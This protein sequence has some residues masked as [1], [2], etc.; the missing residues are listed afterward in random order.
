MRPQLAPQHAHRLCAIHQSA[1]L[2]RQLVGSV[3]CQELTE[4]GA[5][6]APILGPLTGR[7]NLALSQEYRNCLDPQIARTGPKMPSDLS[8]ALRPNVKP[9]C[10]SPAGATGTGPLRRGV[11]H[12]LASKLSRGS[13]GTGRS[14]S[15]RPGSQ[16]RGINAAAGLSTSKLG[17][18]SYVSERT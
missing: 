18:C 15:G 8:D 13:Y 17:A 1:L 16:R 3:H 12:N 6:A 11:H 2:E 5:L 9:G 14:D 7:V 10:S 4:G